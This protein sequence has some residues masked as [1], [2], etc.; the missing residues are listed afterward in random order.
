MIKQEYLFALSMRLSIYFIF[1]H[2]LI[3]ERSGMSVFS[4]PN[5]HF[6]QSREVKLR[7]LPTHEYHYAQPDFSVFSSATWCQCWSNVAGL[8]LKLSHDLFVIMKEWDE[9]M[10]TLRNSFVHLYLFVYLSIYIYIHAYVNFPYSCQCLYFFISTVISIIYLY[11]AYQLCM[12]HIYFHI[13]WYQSASMFY[14]IKI[15]RC[16]C[17]LISSTLR[18]PSTEFM[19]TS[20]RFWRWAAIGHSWC[21]HPLHW[22]P[23]ILPTNRDYCLNVITDR[24]NTI[25]R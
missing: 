8:L 6:Y 1:C 23:F 4:E 10:L 7:V 9:N 15:I 22:T 19:T 11:K 13:L 2:I 12:I 16:S 21:C 25:Q 17:Q 24:K 14:T 18:Y 20:F 5:Y 3:A